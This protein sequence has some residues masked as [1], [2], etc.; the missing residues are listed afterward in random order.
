M[1]NGQRRVLPEHSRPGIAHHF[2]HL[3]AH[4]RFI[5]MNR[6]GIAHRF[7][8]PKWAFFDALQC[9]GFQLGTGFARCHGLMMLLAAID[10]NHQLQGFLFLIYHRI[11]QLSQAC[12]LLKFDY[13][14][15]F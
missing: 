14:I 2:F 7:F 8:R 3:C 1:P 6:A 13:Y 11:T 10:S 4:V 12:T 15:R 5:T 9:I